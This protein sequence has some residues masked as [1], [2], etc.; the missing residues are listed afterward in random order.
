[1]PQ[2]WKWC[3]VIYVLSDAQIWSIGGAVSFMGMDILTGFIGSCVTHTFSSSKMREG[4]GHKALCLCIIALAIMVE[5]AS[6]HIVGLGFSGVTVVA[7]CIYII[8]MEVGSIMENICSAY[9]E[10]RDTPLARMF[11]N[12]ED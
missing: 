1:M 5:A 10:L 6:S 8:V 7:V 9:P 11:E 4:L 3:L 12:K 2:D